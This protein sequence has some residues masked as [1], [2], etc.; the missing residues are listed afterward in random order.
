MSMLG[1]LISTYTFSV[2]PGSSAAAL[3]ASELA[4]RTPS[5]RR[6]VNRVQANVDGHMEQQ[7][8]RRGIRPRVSMPR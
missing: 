8:R 6:I 5:W 4:R 1:R 2:Q 3:F 7:S